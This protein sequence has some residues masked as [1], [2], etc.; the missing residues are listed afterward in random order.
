MPARGFVLLIESN[1]LVSIAVADELEDAG[2]AIAGP[3]S[4]SVAALEWLN[5]NDAIAAV[6]DVVLHDLS[7]LELAHEL[8]HRGVPTIVYSCHSHSVFPDL[9]P[10]LW[11]EKP[12]QFGAVQAALKL[13]LEQRETLHEGQQDSAP[14]SAET[15]FVRSP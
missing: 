4:R 1:G 5:H 6:L 10:T 14:S 2:Y 13:V 11:V 7:C 15:D 12:A 8:R 9:Q 3:F